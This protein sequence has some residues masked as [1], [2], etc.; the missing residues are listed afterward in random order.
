MYHATLDRPLNGSEANR[1]ASGT[2]MLNSENKPLMPA[3][4]EV[5]GE[6]EA[7]VSIQEGRYHQVRRMFAAVG[8]H[9]VNLHRIAIGGLQLPDDLEEGE[10]RI[11]TREEIASVF[12]H[13]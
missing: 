12:L 2:L 8:N 5:L 13:K 6:K 3:G 4:L 1:F 11:A 9:V 7:K 10:W